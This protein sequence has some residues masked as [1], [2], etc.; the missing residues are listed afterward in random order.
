M[1]SRTMAVSKADPRPKDVDREFVLLFLAFDENFSTRMAHNMHKY[2]LKL[3]TG[4]SGEQSGLQDKLRRDKLFRKS[5]LM[6][7]INGRVFC[8]LPG[9]VTKA[10]DRVR[11]HIVSLGNAVDIHT[12]TWEGNTVSYLGHR[13][14]TMQGMPA[15]MRSADSVTQ[16]MGR[17]KLFDNVFKH[18]DQGAV[19]EYVVTARGT[20]SEETA[21]ASPNAAPAATNA[22]GSSTERK[23]YIAADEIEWDYAPEGGDLCTHPGPKDKQKAD[24]SHAEAVKAFGEDGAVFMEGKPTASRI[25]RRYVKAQFREYTSHTFDTLKWGQ[26]SRTNV[27]SQHLGLLGP[28]LRGRVGDK[29]TVVLKNNVRFDVN[30][31]LDGA[32]AATAVVSSDDSKGQSNNKVAGPG[33]TMT[34]S[35]TIRA[36]AGPAEKDGSTLTSLYY[37]D[38]AGKGR[39]TGVNTGLVGPCIV[40]DATRSDGDGAPFKS[41]AAREFVAL[42]ATFDENLSWYR[43]IN[44]LRYA[45]HPETVNPTDPAFKE[46]NKMHTIN[47]L[48]Y[49]NLKGLS[50]RQGQRVRW[51]MHSVG[52]DHGMHTPRWFGNSVTEYGHRRGVLELLPGESRVVDMLADNPGRWLFHC[53]VHDHATAGMKAFFQVTNNL[54]YWKKAQ[55]PQFRQWARKI[56]E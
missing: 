41:E 45:A 16:T 4:G 15:T 48:M 51:Y 24:K 32:L 49:C 6:H 10:G 56:G 25:G 19:V 53:E 21:S 55:G 46:S 43:D 14:T 44:I 35:W 36:D 22:Y 1:G 9:L 38:A 34:Y 29:I 40:G 42:F 33:K 2:L 30:I 13:M 12:P 47:G 39:S 28:V 54:H 8:D 3:G 31:V 26:Q 11:W 37:S 52:S 20:N 23:Y 50:V 5:N 7:S 27:A 18:L 17:F